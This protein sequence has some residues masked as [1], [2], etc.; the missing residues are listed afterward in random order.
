MAV[1]PDWERVKALVRD[2][3]GAVRRDPARLHVMVDRA[4]L[5]ELLDYVHRPPAPG[6]ARNAR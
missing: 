6:P 4:T 3:R 5:R 1:D 2:L